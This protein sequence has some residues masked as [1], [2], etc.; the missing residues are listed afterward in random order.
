VIQPKPGDQYEP[1]QSPVPDPSLP[2]LASK[3]SRNGGALFFS[4]IMILTIF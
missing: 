2:I 3:A 1:G 4:A